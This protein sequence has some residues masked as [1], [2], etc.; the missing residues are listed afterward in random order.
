V[1]RCLAQADA[2]AGR[3]RAHPRVRHAV[4]RFVGTQTGPFE[5]PQGDVPPSGRR[6]ELP[7]ALIVERCPGTDT[8]GSIPVYLDN[9]TLMM[10]LGLMGE[11]VAA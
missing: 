9:L 5:T 6:V 8:A 11:T 1:V 4:P 2:H 10:Q 3:R 7:F